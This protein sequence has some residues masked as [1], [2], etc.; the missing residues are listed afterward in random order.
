MIETPWVVAKPSTLSA[1]SSDADLGSATTIRGLLASDDRP[2]SDDA[3]GSLARFDADELVRLCT[4]VQSTAWGPRLLERL[5][6]ALG[7]CFCSPSTWMLPAA[8]T[9]TRSLKVGSVGA[10]RLRGEE[11]LLRLP[12]GE[13][14]DCSAATVATGPDDGARW[15]V[16]PSRSKTG[17]RRNVS[18]SKLE[19]CLRAEP[20]LPVL[21]RSEANGSRSSRP[22]L[23]GLR[24]WLLL[25]FSCDRRAVAC[26]AND[27]TAL[28]RTRSPSSIF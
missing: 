1:S 18:W 12:L 28:E 3:R 8:L 21:R 10:R 25:L 15:E 9:R 27:G 5:R 26:G 22:T 20:E 13:R 7:H 6:W 19:T 23:S 11:V 4:V 17:S 24:L 16:A 2:D 14:A